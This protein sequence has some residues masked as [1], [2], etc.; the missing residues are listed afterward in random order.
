MPMK[1]HENVGETM[2]IGDAYIKIL[3]ATNMR[4]ILVIDA[5]EDIPI[6]RGAN[7]YKKLKKGG[8]SYDNDFVCY[9]KDTGLIHISEAERTI[10]EGINVDAADLP[11][12]GKMQR[13]C[14]SDRGKQSDAIVRNS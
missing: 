1:F 6:L 13:D 10:D 4:V 8:F 5:P 11:G 7:L 14:D 9:R 2:K 12:N 3:H